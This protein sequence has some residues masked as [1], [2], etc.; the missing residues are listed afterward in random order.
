VAIIVDQIR[1]LIQ[2][3]DDEDK[4]KNLIPILVKKYINETSE[5]R[6]KWLICA[7]FAKGYH[8]SVIDEESRTL[9]SPISTD[10]R[11]RCKTNKIS[12]YI[13]HMSSR[14][15]RTKPVWEGVPKDL[16]LEE[17][18][19]AKSASAFLQQHA[20][21]QELDVKRIKI[22]N[23]LLVFGN[24][25]IICNDV[26]DKHKFQTLPKYEKSGEPIINVETGEQETMKIS[27]RDIDISPILPHCL[28]CSNDDSNLDDK[29]HVLIHR[30]KD[31]DY[32]KNQYGSKL[33][34]KVKP[35]GKGFSS[36]QF[37]LD[38][39]KT[40][41]GN[42]NDEGA[43]ETLYLQKPSEIN[44]DGSIVTFS[45]GVILNRKKWPDSFS[46]IDGYP[47]V[48]FKW[49]EPPPGE[50]FSRSPLEDQIPLNRDINE[51]I[52]I[53]MENTS[54]MGHLKWMNPLGSGVKEITDL[55]GEIINFNPGFMPTP[56]VV[57]PLPE[58]IARIYNILCSELEDIQMLHSVSTGE[59]STNVRS[60]V[61]IE[62]LQEQDMM[63]LSIVD[64]L[65]EEA[66]KN[67][68]K[69]I[70]QIGIKTLDQPRLV[71]Y[72]GNGRRRTIQ[73]FTN[74]MLN[75]NSDVNVRLVDS[76]LRTK[77][78]TQNLIL[79]LF[80]RGMITDNLGK[81][82]PVQAMKL[83]EFALPDSVYDKDEAQRNI[84]YDEN[85]ELLTGTQV[86]VEDWHFHFVHLSAHDDWFNSS[87][88]KAETI[89]NPRVR[90]ISIQHRMEHIQRI[91]AAMQSQGATPSPTG[92]GKPT[93]Q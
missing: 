21:N 25:F 67:L 39:I 63:P 18:N 65:S 88:W 24:S 14:V 87:E 71:R 38:N 8:Y 68:G 12:S 22:A 30:W 3:K 4:I 80:T 60:R 32:F 31:L 76:H 35:E 72:I 81:V 36:G 74:K 7:A 42:Q 85:D 79:E 20:R 77:T 1:N 5:I 37:S 15:T 59:G 51:V 58:Y 10:G 50:F 61:G 92:V 70:L 83:L 16:S 48:H 44:K 34:G 52:S 57:N 56:S 23:H 43:N 17:I 89:R 9:V 19:A 90:E 46:E 78:Q 49:G 82:D 73:D 13:W 54:N 47:I 28:L 40:D 29:W 26:E 2:K 45:N 86:P 53:F 64:S 33:G 66:Y 55:S 84:A 69:K 6:L 41:R 93:S 62:A 75:G 27:Y 91:M 11:K